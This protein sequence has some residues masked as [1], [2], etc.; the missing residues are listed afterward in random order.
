M[1]D[2]IKEFET[3]LNEVK[4][5]RKALSHMG[6]KM[7][8]HRCLAIQ[9]HLYQSYPPEVKQIIKEKETNL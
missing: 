6:K 5:K 7:P 8:I 2:L 1:K 9:G 3:K 4:T